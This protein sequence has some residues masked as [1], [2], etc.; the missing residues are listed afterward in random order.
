MH[1]QVIRPLWKCIHIIVSD[2]K[3]SPNTWDALVQFWCQYY[4]PIMVACRPCGLPPLRF[5][6]HQTSIRLTLAHKKIIHNISARVCVCVIARLQPLR[7]S[8]IYLLWR[9]L[10]DS[11]T[12]S[13]IITQTDEPLLFLNSQLD[14][15][16]YIFSPSNSKHP[17]GIKCIL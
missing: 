2:S 17:H 12:Y 3:P 11:Q 16:F 5:F 15:N 1:N 8:C 14:A 9:I 10:C 4:F 13:Y 7:D 6:R